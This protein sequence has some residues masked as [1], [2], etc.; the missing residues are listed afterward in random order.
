MTEQKTLTTNEARAYVDLHTD[1]VGRPRHRQ[2]WDRWL[3]KGWIIPLIPGTKGRQ[4]IY[5]IESVD[6]LVARINKRGKGNWKTLT[7]P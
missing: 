1:K 6:R 3:R 7:N 4:S 2:Q 5:T